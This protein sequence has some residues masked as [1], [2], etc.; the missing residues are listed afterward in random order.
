MRVCVCGYGTRGDARHHHRRRRRR[1]AR[2]SRLNLSG[3]TLGSVALCA[4]LRKHEIIRMYYVGILYPVRVF[5]CVRCECPCP[6]IELLLF[7]CAHSAGLYLLIVINICS[8]ILRTCFDVVAVVRQV[9][10]AQRAARRRRRRRHRRRMLILHA[11]FSSRTSLHTHIHAHSNESC[12]TL[13]QAQLRL[14]LY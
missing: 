14:T 11:E 9:Q 4:V 5:V 2:P 3:R 1:Y 10:V 13:A 6:V 8:C 7:S 12:G